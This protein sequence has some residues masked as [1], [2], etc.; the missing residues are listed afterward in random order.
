MNDT[1]S[2][3]SYF[4]RYMLQENLN[5]TTFARMA[6]IN[7]GTLS[8]I[9]NN[10]K[11]LTVDHLDRLTAV[12]NLPA[13]NFY[14]QY[15]QEYL[16]ILTPNWRRFKPFIYRCAELHRLECIQNVLH[17]LLENLMYT[18]LLFEIAED[19]FLQGKHE[20]AALLFENVAASEKHQH[21]E[22]LALSQYRLF[23]IRLGADQ[24][25]NY[26]A[27]MQFEPFVER[28]DEIE[29]L[30]AL[31]ELINT[32]RSI[33]RWDKALDI[34][35]KLNHL[36]KNQY[37]LIHLT[38]K[39][40]KKSY[41][42]P[43]RPLFFYVAFSNSFIGAAYYEQ[44]NYEQALQIAVDSAD[45]SWV[46]ETDEETLYWKNLFYE[47]MQANILLT[48]LMA[49]E[50]DVLP[51]YVNY[52]ESREEELPT[53]LWNIITAANRHNI[54]VDHIL[55]KFEKEI[56]NL[57]QKKGSSIY[58]QKNINNQV[59]G[60]LSEL[61]DYYFFRDDYD[62]SFY[63]LSEWMLKSSKINDDHAV[64]RYKKLYEHLREKLSL[65]TN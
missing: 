35:I 33:R 7:A 27:A 8:S 46:K 49:G 9:I 53:G 1:I 38:K 56:S 63:F 64:L 42:K 4:K 26:Q 18:P 59:V 57:F 41:K 65:T 32:Y 20:V 43:V 13:G 5:L 17:L 34:A 10:N 19:L 52:I 16:T 14:E 44:E 58:D 25:K 51:E 45:L 15:I 2:I 55:A 12:M 47:W 6:G 62:K 37:A 39:S 3:L 60:L 11:A 36:A 21:S 30:D 61:T 31:R 50:M 48:R 28:L 54:N 24:E 40:K 23:L 22:R 29:Q